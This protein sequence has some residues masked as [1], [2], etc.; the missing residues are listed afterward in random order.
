MSKLSDVTEE[1]RNGRGI[2]GLYPAADEQTLKDFAI[3]RKAKGR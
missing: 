3:W 1:V 2:F